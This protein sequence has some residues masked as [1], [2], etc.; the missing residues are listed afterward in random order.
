MRGRIEDGEEVVIEANAH[1]LL[2]GNNL[3]KVNGW[4]SRDDV[5]GRVLEPESGTD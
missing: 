5:I 1:S 3:G 2:I 4:A